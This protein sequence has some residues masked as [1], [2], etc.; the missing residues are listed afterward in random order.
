LV[1]KSS[2]LTNIPDQE[3]TKQ[4]NVLDISFVRRENVILGVIT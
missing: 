4:K 1:Y 2:A 3:K